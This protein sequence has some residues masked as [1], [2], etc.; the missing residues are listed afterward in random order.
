MISTTLRKPTY[1][2]SLD[3]YFRGGFSIDIVLLTF[4][5]GHLQILLQEKEDLPAQNEIGL[6]GKLILPNEEVDGAMNSFLI[7]LIGTFDFYK[8]QLHTF[9]NVG[10]HPLGRVVS[11]AYYGLISGER[12]KWNLPKTL[13]W[14]PLSAVPELAYDHRDILSLVMDR[15]KKGLLQHP[16]VF[17]LLPQKFILSDVISIYEEVF[18][19]KVDASNFR[20][21]LKK[22]N[23][24]APTESYQRPYGG[25]GRPARK[26]VIREDQIQYEREENV[27]F[28]F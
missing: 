12:L 22:S 26:Y 23:L 9:S 13:A 5:Q 20:R 6:P 16:I 17:E 21:Q 19:K 28:N 3:L 11:F 27:Q 2:E 14:Y 1:T 25:I 18:G 24:I 8:K 7:S 15:F 10:R 4:D